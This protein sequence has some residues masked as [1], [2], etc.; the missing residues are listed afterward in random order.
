MIRLALALALVAHLRHQGFR[1]FD[2]QFV[3]PHLASLGAVEISRAAFQRQLRAAI[4]QPAS[5]AGPVPDP[6]S[7][8]QL[9]TQTS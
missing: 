6:Y 7:V 9:S 2:T 5:F 4:T 8:T 1:L 3:T